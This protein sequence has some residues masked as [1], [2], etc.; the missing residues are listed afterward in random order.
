MAHSIESRPPFCNHKIIEHRFKMIKE[1][2]FEKNVGKLCIKK[3]ASKYFSEDFVFS[4]KVGFTAP[5]S[6]FLYD[7][8]VWGSL[9]TSLNFDLL[10][11]FINIQ[12]L[13]K[14]LNISNANEKFTGNNLK[15]LFYALNFQLWHECF[16]E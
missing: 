11:N 5:L 9:L 4:K 8:S 3:I 14:I 15:L 16:F 7:K 6:D 13:K 2:I 12:P 10:D 1:Q